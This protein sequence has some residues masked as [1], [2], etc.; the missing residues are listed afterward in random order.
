MSFLHSLTNFPIWSVP[1]M[2]QTFIGETQ[3]EGSREIFTSDLVSPDE[4]PD[5][6][7]GKIQV[8]RVRLGEKPKEEWKGYYCSYVKHLVAESKSVC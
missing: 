4:S 1:R 5:G 2:P 8:T 6:L 3:S 7:L